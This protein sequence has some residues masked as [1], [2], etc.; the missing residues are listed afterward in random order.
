MIDL[1]DE[2]LAEV[3]SIFQHHLPNTPVKAFGSRV[4]GRAKPFSDL[5]LVV[6]GDKPISQH[7]LNDIKLALS[8]SDLPIRV[9]VVDWHAID[10]EFRAVI[11]NHC[12]DL[13]N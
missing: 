5:D 3:K 7:K 6:M 8:E 9:D 10:D 2:Y 13:L 12:E 4:T 11:H 1:A